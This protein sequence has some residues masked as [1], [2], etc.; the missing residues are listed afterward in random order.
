M[1]FMLGPATL[2]GITYGIVNGGSGWLTGLDAAYLV[3]IALMVSGRWYEQRS[4]MAMTA[5]GKPATWETFAA[6]SRC[7]C[8][9]PLVFG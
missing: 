6:T 1:W 8:L 7:C 3:V 2:V 4:G 5:E 9:S